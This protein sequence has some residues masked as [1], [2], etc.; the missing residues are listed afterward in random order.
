MIC[1]CLIKTSEKEQLLIELT[2]CRKI[3]SD[4]HGREK[5]LREQLQLYTEKYDEFQTSLKKSNDVF[6][7]YKTEIDKVSGINKKKP[8][9]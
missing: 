5:A 3:I 4:L 8:F 2:K 6:T 7:G 1:F 9:D